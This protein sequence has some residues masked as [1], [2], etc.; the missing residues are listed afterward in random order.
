MITPVNVA[1]HL[2]DRIDV[3]PNPEPST[4]D[5]ITLES[6]G[7]YYFNFKVS[8]TEYSYDD[9]TNGVFFPH[10]NKIK[11]TSFLEFHL[12]KEVI[13]N[14]DVLD[15]DFI[16]YY[17]HTRNLPTETKEN[18]AK[19]LEYYIPFG[20]DDLRDN[21]KDLITTFHPTSLLVGKWRL[22]IVNMYS[23]YNISTFNF[24]ISPPRLPLITVITH[25]GFTK[26]KVEFENAIE[27][28]YTFESLH[29][30]SINESDRK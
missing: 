26:Y 19:Y 27:D 28:S 17:N 10:D 11:L 12:E 29:F 24:E 1:T 22:K 18:G 20:L 30:D 15:A 6:D 9:L 2:T 3:P 23:K 4:K 8:N 25:I 21:L 7:L 5:F 13:E 16:I 14:S